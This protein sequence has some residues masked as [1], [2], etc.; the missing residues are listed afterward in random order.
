[1]C[2][3]YF[4]FYWPSNLVFVVRCVT[5]IPNLRKIGHKLRSLSWTI[6]IWDRHTDTHTDIHSSDLGIC[7]VSCTALDRQWQQMMPLSSYVYRRKTPSMYVCSLCVSLTAQLCRYLLYALLIAYSLLSKW[8]SCSP[9]DNYKVVKL[10]CYFW[11]L[12]EIN[13]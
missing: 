12:L 1:M 4:R 6:G 8:P 7:P 13:K 2:V 11:A 10:L 5:Y 9:S 3:Y